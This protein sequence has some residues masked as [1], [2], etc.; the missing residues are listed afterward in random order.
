MRLEFR[1]LFLRPARQQQAEPSL[2]ANEARLRLLLGSVR[3]YAIYMLDP[4]G[5]VVSWNPGAEQIKGYRAEEIIGQHFSRFYVPEDVA[6]GRPEAALRAAAAEGR[7]E[8]ENWRIRKDGSR[9]WADVVITAVRDDRGTLLGFAKVTRDLT[10]RQRAEEALRGSEERFRILAVTANDAIITADRHG[11]ITYFN[12]GA[13]RIFGYGATEVNGKPLTVLMPERFRDAHHAGIA[14]YL[15]TGEARVVGKTVELAGQKKNGAEFP[16]E[17]SLASWQRGS[18]IAFTA[19]IRDVTERKRVEETLRRHTAQVEAANA[20]LDAFAYSVS[21]DLRAPLRGID[22][23]SQALLEDYADRLDDAGKD[24]LTR[25]RSA[26]QRMATLID[27]LLNLSR[28]TRSEMHVGPLDLSA[29][30]MGIAEGLQK[31]DPARRVE[32]A[33]APGLHVSADPGLM[34]AVLQNL[35]EN[36]WKFTGKLPD[37]RIEVGSVPHDGG[38]AYFVRDNGAGFDMTYVHKLFGAFQRLHGSGPSA[39]RPSHDMP[40]LVLLDLK[41]PRVDG[42]EVLRRL[43]ADPRTHLLPVVILTSSKEE[44]D[45]VNSYSLG[46]NSYVRKPVDFGE[47]TE[48]I[49]QLGLYWLILNEAP[50]T[51]RTG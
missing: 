15:A 32:V 31:R 1:R 11:N 35:L 7:Y 19:I 14:R 51:K 24:Y 38:R 44:R 33:I 23:F 9:I 18:E 6:A 25:V 50:P 26:S 43:R 42:L 2:R 49:R 3:D 16:L 45:L 21:H 39:G 46:A 36:A 30:A 41:L 22:G 8:E 4:T 20:E 10:E 28:V 40:Q 27:D 48:A 5:H 34:R 47:F 13:E 12:P 37:A 17:L 29:L